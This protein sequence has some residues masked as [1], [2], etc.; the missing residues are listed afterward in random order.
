MTLRVT[1]CPAMIVVVLSGCVVTAGAV[2]L[3]FTVTTTVLLSAVPQPF[4]TRTQYDVVAD[5]V[6]L[7]E[8]VV[9]PAIGLAVFDAVPVYHWK[10]RLVPVATT[11]SADVSP[12]PIVE[13]FG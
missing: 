6:T 8:A 4:E 1:F 9:P 3:V 11:V 2:Q 10:V 5:G 12:E 7:I 13:G